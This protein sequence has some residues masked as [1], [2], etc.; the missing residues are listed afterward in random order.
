MTFL[1]A[2]L[3]LIAG[4][5]IGL[6]LLYLLS[7][8]DAASIPSSPPPAFSDADAR[9]ILNQAGF[10]IIEKEKRLPL[11]VYVNEKSHLANITVDYLVKK[12]KK[13]YAVKV[14]SGLGVNATDPTTIRQLIEYDYSGSADGV[15]LLDMENGELHMVSFKMPKSGRDRLL[16]WLFLAFI[17]FLIIVIIF[18]FFKVRLI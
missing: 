13:T 16:T 6:L 12:E 15:L 4:L 14:K 5:L 9:A 17:I 18:L 8:R 1:Y 11:I 10:E 2:M 7:K 3:G